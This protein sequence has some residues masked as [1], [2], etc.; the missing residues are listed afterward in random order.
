MERGNETELTNQ[1]YI[2][3]LKL[4]NGTITEDHP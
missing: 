2:Y 1:T 3:A 4:T